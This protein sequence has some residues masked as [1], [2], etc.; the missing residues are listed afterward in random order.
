MTDSL[1]IVFAKDPVPGRVKT[2]LAA[3]LGDDRAAGIYRALAEAAWSVC[4]GAQE[5]LPCALWLYVDSAEG[6][7]G[8]DPWLVGADAVVPQPAGDLGVRIAKAFRLGF[9]AGFR[10]VAIV[11]TD[12]PG[13]HIG[14]FRAAFLGCGEGHAVLGPATDG[15][16]YLLAL[17]AAPEALFQ[18]LPW[19][20]PDTGAALRARGAGLGLAW[21]ELAPLRDIDTPEDWAWFRGTSPGAAIAAR[22]RA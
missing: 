2:R 1:L 5:A 21:T 12:V 17:G 6:W 3:Q 7:A 14:L 9:A 11:G 19:S 15:G 13:L 8:M 18:G 10:R 20:T 22:L 4:R 16:F